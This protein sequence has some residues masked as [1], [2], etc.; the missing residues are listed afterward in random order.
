VTLEGIR[1]PRN[2]VGHMNFPNAYDRTTI[3]NAYSQL[4]SLLGDLTAFPI[5]IIVP[6]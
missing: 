4:P 5:P 2:L 1:V 3:D 6:K